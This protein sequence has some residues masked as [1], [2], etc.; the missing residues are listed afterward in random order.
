MPP[1]KGKKAARAKKRTTT[2]AP[3][4]APGSGGGGGGSG[5]GAGSPGGGEWSA[6]LK[7]AHELADGPEPDKALPLYQ[8]V[9][10]LN[11]MCTDAMDAAAEIL[12]ECGEP[13]QAQQLLQESVRIA[14]GANAAKL[15]TLAQLLEADAA[16]A[17]YQRGIDLLTAEMQGALIVSDAGAARGKR[18]QLCSAHCGVVELHMTDLCMAESAEAVCERHIALAESFDTGAADWV[19][20]KASLRLSQQRPED[21]AALMAEALARLA[22]CYNPHSMTI[23][24]LEAV[25]EGQLELP[26]LPFRLQT[27]KLL[28]EVEQHA[29]AAAVLCGMVEEDD[30]NIEIWFLLGM[31]YSSDALRDYEGA[32]EALERA[33]D[34]F[35]KVAEDM[36]AAGQPFPYGQQAAAVQE[37][38]AEVSAKM[39]GSA[40]GGAPAV[41]AAGGEGDGDEDMD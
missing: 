28:L 19:Q 37:L 5:G 40:G 1:K 32:L 34:M 26:E 41:A 38:L 8:R 20:M 17:A 12:V 21:A 29:Q 23:A 31:C 6:L 30:T 15:L 18:A 14:P 7:Q 27:A 16:A 11:G 33:R 35:A 24:E 39:G 36:A 25:P 9:L 10:Q 13:E 22:A 4:G 2:A 3:P